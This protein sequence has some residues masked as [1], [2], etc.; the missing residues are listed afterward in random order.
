MK[1]IVPIMVYHGTDQELLRETIRS[2]EP[3]SDVLT[4]RLF[5]GSNGE[6]NI[7]IRRAE[8]IEE[9]YMNN[10]EGFTHI[11]FMDDSDLIAEDGFRTALEEMSDIGI[12]LKEKAFNGLDS[13]K[14]CCR[15]ILRLDHSYELSRHTLTRGV[16][17]RQFAEE[18][19]WRLKTPRSSKVAYLWRYTGERPH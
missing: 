9:I 2:T 19:N 11:M 14:Y 3:F 13:E 15:H 7:G 17:D 5:P 12:Y 16:K 4:V 6:P 18:V 10:D 8:I 1:I